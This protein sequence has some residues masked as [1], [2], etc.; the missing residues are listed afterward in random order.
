MKAVID[1]RLFET[2]GAATI[3]EAARRLGLSIP[4]LCDHSRLDPAAA[5]RLCLVEIAGRRDPV[6]ACA[7]ALEDGMRVTTDTPS[8]RTL[9]RGVMEMILAEHPSA[10]LFCAERRDCREPKA[11]LR[12]TGEPTGCVLCPKDGSCRLQDAAAAVGLERTAFPEAPRAAEPRR[13][14]PLIDR[15]AGLCILCGLCV[16]VCRDLRGASVLSFI[17]R[18]GQTSVGTALDGTLLEAG[19]RFCG[20]CVDVCPTGA[21]LERSVRYRKVDEEK[22]IVC[23][24]CGEGCLLEVELERGRMVGTKPADG[25]ANRGQ[26]CVKGRFLTAEIHAFPGRLT[27]PFI[28][29]A[30]HLVPAEWDE[31]LAAAAAGLRADSGPFAAIASAQ[32]SCEDLWALRAL[33][34][35]GFGSGGFRLAEPPAPLGRIQAAAGIGPA[36]GLPDLPHAGLAGMKAIVVFDEDLPV[37]APMVGLGVVQAVRRGAR[38]IVFGP[39]ETCLD[40]SAKVRVRAGSEAAAEFLLDL[41][42]EL[43]G[44]AGERGEPGWAELRKAIRARSEGNRRDRRSHPDEKTVRIAGILDKRKPAA[45]IFGPRFVAGESG[46]RNAAALWNLA[47]LVGAELVPIAWEANARGGAA[48]LG[49]EAATPTCGETMAAA[50]RL[51]LASDVPLD[52]VRPEAFVATLAAFEGRSSERADVVLPR[53]LF[54]EQD[55]TWVNREGR[56]QR[57]RAAVLPPGEARPI[58]RIAADLGRAIGRNPGPASADEIMSEIART[59]PA[60]AGAA[61][62]R[63]GHNPVFLAWPKRPTGRFA[64]IPAPAAADRPAEPVADPDGFQG[65]SAGTALKSLKAIRRR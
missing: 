59:V 38:L 33:T 36:E 48:L 64:A 5:C 60:F 7:T 10:C 13:D 3:L 43:S 21:L 47:E 45:F 31:A 11:G 37:T 49:A 14:D 26:V 30:G 42:A 56:I 34:R 58:W 39:H 2:A 54:A 24:L 32:D 52:A 46:R 15:D 53:T 20:A 22:P 57:S 63:P 18:G 55:G 27:T 12:K 6:P 29:R 40:R 16:R 50:G 17:G 44:S 62:A 41:L 4:T 9:R 25:P 28:R 51:L 35:D 8:L 19:C 61:A 1:G 65:L 23:A